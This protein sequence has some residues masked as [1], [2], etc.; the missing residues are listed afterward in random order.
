MISKV[1]DNIQ[2]AANKAVRPDFTYPGNSSS[3]DT[4]AENSLN[5]TALI[6]FCGSVAAM[7]L[8]SIWRQVIMVGLAVLQM[9]WGERFVVELSV[10]VVAAVERQAPKKDSSGF[11]I[12]HSINYQNAGHLFPL[13]GDTKLFLSF[14]HKKFISHHQPINRYFKARP[15]TPVCHYTTMTIQKTEIT[16]KGSIEIVSDFFFTAINSILYQRGT[17]RSMLY[18]CFA[19]SPAHV[20]CTCNKLL[21]SEYIRVAQYRYLVLFTSFNASLIYQGFIY[22][23]RSNV[24]QNMVLQC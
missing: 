8:V 5:V 7:R 6:P 17:Y 24:S 14:H 1:S 15:T 18:V 23:R 19:C 10:L 16:L 22:P 20:Q 21:Y 9:G 12:P 3:I 13:P 4:R 11:H 2:Y